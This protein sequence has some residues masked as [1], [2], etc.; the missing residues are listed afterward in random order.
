MKFSIILTLPSLTLTNER[1]LKYYPSALI[2]AIFRQQLHGGNDIP[3]IGHIMSYHY[4]ITIIYL[5]SSIMIDVH[6]VYIPPNTFT[7]IDAW[8]LNRIKYY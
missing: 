3:Y 1:H 4:D 2:I 7:P 8:V 6:S 5:Y